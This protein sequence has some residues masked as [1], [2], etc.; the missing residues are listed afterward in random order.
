MAVDSFQAARWGVTRKMEKKLDTT[1]AILETENSS[2][3]SSQT[4]VSLHKKYC[5]IDMNPS[6][7]FSSS[8][9]GHVVIYFNHGIVLS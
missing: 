8:C 2:I 9:R 3:T 7:P 6:V 1:Q 5:Y 4:F